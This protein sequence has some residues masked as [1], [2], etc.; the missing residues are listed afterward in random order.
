[1]ESN[2]YTIDAL[3]C[4]RSLTTLLNAV[5]IAAGMSVGGQN[6]FAASENIWCVR[7]KIPSKIVYLD[8]FFAF[9]T[10]QDK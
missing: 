1:M 6:I 2:F 8:E 5:F 9:S 10:F 4:V 7:S 3:F